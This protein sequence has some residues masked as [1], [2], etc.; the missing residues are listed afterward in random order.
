MW[1]QTARVAVRSWRLAHRSGAWDLALVVV[2][3]LVYYVVRGMVDGRAP[4]AV[5]R[6]IRIVE[7]ERALG[8]FWERQVQGVVLT[9]QVL[10]DIF[11]YIYVY[12]HL[13]LICIVALAMFLFRRPIYVLYRNAFFL[14]GGIGL[15]CFTFLPTAPPRL[16]PWPYGLVDTVAAFSHISYDSQPAALVNQY[17]AL[18]SLHFA[19]N[20]LLALAILEATRN[21]LLR[22][23]AVMMP[24]AM[25]VAI[26]ATANHFILDIVAGAVVALLGLGLARLWQ[27]Q[28]P[29]LWRRL[30]RRAVP[31]STVAV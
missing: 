17:A 8:L 11:N 19:W 30:R 21:P 10:V 24:L 26:V 27:R 1:Q 18:P 13:P 31:V 7:L 2:A 12:G 14:A 15:L 9:S 16:L 5:S 3:Y 6:A 4:E 28:G 23:V 20:L 25:A 29:R 22:A